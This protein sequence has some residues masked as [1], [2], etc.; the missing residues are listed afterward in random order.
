MFPGGDIPDA[1]HSHSADLWNGSMVVTGG[2]GSHLRPLRSVHVLDVQR[3][4]WQQ[5]RPQPQLVPRSVWC[6]ITGITIS[7]LLAFFP[8][9][10]GSASSLGFFCTCSWREPLGLSGTGFYRLDGVPLTQ[11]T[12]RWKKLIKIM[13]WSGWWVGECF[14]WYRLTR[15]V[16]DKGP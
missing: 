9:Q 10:P 16:P 4:Q 6:V 8:G 5:L 15:V 2:L 1:W 11:P 12:D 14:F 13:W 3:L 7:V